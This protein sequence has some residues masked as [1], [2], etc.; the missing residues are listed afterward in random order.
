MFTIVIIIGIHHDHIFYHLI[1]IPHILY[2]LTPFMYMMY[3]RLVLLIGIVFFLL[4][5]PSRLNH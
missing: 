4:I 1:F 5:M 3:E 2:R